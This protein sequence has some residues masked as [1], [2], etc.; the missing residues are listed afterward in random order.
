M[1]AILPGAHFE[2]VAGVV[3][4]LE[5]PQAHL[6]SPGI[7]QV[8]QR[9]CSALA[10]PITAFGRK[11]LYAITKS[12]RLLL[13]A[14]RSLGRVAVERISQESLTAALLQ[15][16]GFTSFRPEAVVRLQPICSVVRS[17]LDTLVLLRLRASLLH[18]NPHWLW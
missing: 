1:L 16:W 10:T 13:S 14:K 15:V 7:C 9:Q 5:S 3:L 18:Q 12:D 4:F 8:V 11:Q 17:Q 6:D 2:Q